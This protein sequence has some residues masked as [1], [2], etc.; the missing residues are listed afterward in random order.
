FLLERGADPN[1]AID[2]TTALHA[3][4]GSV[5]TWL[6]GWNR[7]HGNGGAGYVEKGR[8]ALDQRLPLV[9]ALLA[10]GA[11]PHA[12]PTASAMIAGGF[13]RNGAF[14][15]F[16]IGT[17]DVSSASPLWVAAYSM[18]GGGGFGGLSAANNVRSS[19]EIMRTLLRAGAD[20]NLRTA[21]GTTPL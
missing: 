3:A 14:D 21:D 20:P 11:E 13:L 4:A 6:K 8:L 12:R 7:R 10:K 15:N 17:G 1:G 5:D 18:N 9:K 2:G 19:G 16:T